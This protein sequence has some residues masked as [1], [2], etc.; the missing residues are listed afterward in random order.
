MLKKTFFLLL[1]TAFFLPFA[2]LSE[3][4][5]ALRIADTLPEELPVLKSAAM[6]L[7]MQQNVGVTFEKNSDLTKA[8][9]ELA[10]GKYDVVLAVESAL[11][12]SAKTLDRTCF[13]IDT[14]AIYLNSMNLVNDGAEQLFKKAWISPRPSWRLFGGG[15][16]QIHLM[17]LNKG[18]PGSGIF[19]FWLGKNSPGIYLGL[20]ST[21]EILIM[22]GDDTEALAISRFAEGY[23][24]DKV[25]AV[26]VNGVSPSLETI[27]NGKYPL[28]WRYVAI[29]A[30]KDAS[31]P[32]SFIDL[33]SSEKFQDKFESAG[34]VLP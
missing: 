1:L 17:G 8:L 19:R 23:P 26:A 31:A 25:K 4:A 29:V 32:K 22:A 5:I 34:L 24:V 14:L 30:K 13:A 21:R 33:L 20:N 11:P 2:L 28:A 6:L 9:T 27:R 7:A 18:R 15:N 3:E 12:E 16:R 10:D